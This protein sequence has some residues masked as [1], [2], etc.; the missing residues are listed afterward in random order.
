MTDSATH[1]SPV[2]QPA[3]APAMPSAEE[4][5]GLNDTHGLGAAIG[6]LNPLSA[7]QGKTAFSVMSAFFEAGEQVEVLV[8][9]RYLGELA[10]L[11]LTNQRLLIANAREWKADVVEFVFGP[12]LTIQGWQDDRTAALVIQDDHFAATIDSV[13]DRSI[14]QQLAA[15]L[16]S[17]TQPE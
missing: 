8:Q 12:S 14:A 15:G 5:K 11:A 16:R 4:G 7:Q 3:T 1:N 17:H 10:A 13:A 9:G 2:P 6:Q